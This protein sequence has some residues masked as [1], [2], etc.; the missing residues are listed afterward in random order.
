MA[1]FACFVSIY[2]LVCNVEAFTLG[3]GH[4]HPQRQFA[5]RISPL[6]ASSSTTTNGSNTFPVNPY[7][8]VQASVNKLD[9]EEDED[10]DED[11]S[12][13]QHIFDSI[14]TIHCTHREPDYLIPW[15]NMHQSTSTSSGFV[16]TIDG[17]D[18]NRRIMTN[19]HS[20]EYGSIVQV[21]KRGDSQKYLA[22]VEAIGQECDLALLK[23]ENQEFWDNLVGLEFG[24]LPELQDEVEVLGY[25]TGGS[26]LSVTSGVVS[27]IEVQEYAQ[28][29]AHLLAMQID[30]AINA[31]N[32]GG[33]VV[34]LDGKVVGVA[35]QSLTSAENIG[36]VVPVPIVQH[37]LEN[38]R[39]N[40]KFRGFCGLGMRL[41]TL[42]NESF[43]KS[44]GMLPKGL[45]PYTGIRIRDLA[46]MSQ[47][48]DILQPGDVILELDTIDVANDGKIPFRTGERVALLSYLQT[49]FAGDLVALKLLRN[50]TPVE[51]QA[52]VAIMQDLVPSQWNSQPPPYLIVGGLV[53]TTLSCPYLKQ[54]EAFEDFVSDELS[55]LLGFVNRSV[56]QSQ[57]QVVIMCQVLAHSTNLGYD[58]LTDLHL[59]KCNGV[60]IRNLQQIHKLLF[61]TLDDEFVTLEFAPE[62][63]MIVLERSSLQQATEDVCEE[64]SIR[65]PWRF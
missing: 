48:K 9:N 44:L 33:P 42:E 26:S 43:R 62:G 65:Q 15:Q 58:K 6:S 14:V 21:Q 7:W 13:P 37:F 53:F 36:Y 61:E 55:Y 2:V 40:G 47:A 23:L 59:T 18:D 10:E 41:S 22:L 31:G 30:A 46:P 35:F 54:A 38:I 8:P 57:D 19:A 56:K 28:A 49:K 12:W 60:E 1:H 32:S 64:H 17:K 3:G 20:V 34:D 52:P 50:G 24:S 27:R 25:P 11:D 63:R 45:P 29:G 5:L 4:H 51:V 16:I 39:R